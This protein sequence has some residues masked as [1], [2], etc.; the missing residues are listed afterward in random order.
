MYTTIKRLGQGKFGEA[1]LINHK[2]YGIAVMKEIKLDRTS[3]DAVERV[4]NEVNTLYELTK[5]GKCPWVI[6]FYDHMSMPKSHLI[7]LEYFDGYE[8][9]D[10]A[11]KLDLSSKEGMNK[12]LFICGEV[13]DAVKCIHD[14]GVVHRDLKLENIMFNEYGI[15][16]IDFGSACRMR[17]LTER[18]TCNKFSGT[19]LYISPELYGKSD[20][21]ILTWEQQKSIDVW[22]IGH[23]FYAL[24][25]GKKLYQRKNATLASVK[26]DALS[27]NQ[28]L[29]F[30][31]EAAPHNGVNQMIL[32][33]LDPDY[34]QRLINF[35]NIHIVLLG[36]KVIN[37]QDDEVILF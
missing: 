24:A 11:G 28:N 37:S 27:K 31:K 21:G 14:K 5:T 30:I 8:L 36:L 26:E 35:D 13:S 10:I 33:L 4:L 22:A 23:V 16:L 15:K 19:P 17:K 32:S 18:T 25:Y 7:F 6:R 3:T 1:S 2:R 34:S 20:Y 12:Y 9:K 29:F